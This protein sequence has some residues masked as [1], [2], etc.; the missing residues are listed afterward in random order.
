MC[1]L[2]LDLNWDLSLM[3]PK[4]MNISL[5]FFLL[6]LRCGKSSQLLVSCGEESN[7]RT[8]ASKAFKNGTHSAKKLA[9]EHRN[10]FFPEVSTACID[11][12]SVAFTACARCV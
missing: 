8:I 2:W 1:V 3:F 10:I 4:L 5:F 9:D 12:M 6:D 11:K 7:C